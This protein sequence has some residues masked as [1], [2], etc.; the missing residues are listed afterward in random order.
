MNKNSEFGVPF[1][2]KPSW[3]WQGMTLVDDQDKPQATIRR[4]PDL[5]WMENQAP[6]EAPDGRLMV[7]EGSTYPEP[8]FR[9]LR[10]GFFKANGKVES[11]T[12][13]P[14][15]MPDVS[16]SAYDGINCYFIVKEGLLAMNKVGIPLWIYR[17]PNWNSQNSWKVFPSLNGLA[18]YDGVRTVSWFDPK[19][20]NVNANPISLAMG[21]SPMFYA[22]QNR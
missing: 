21:S 12:F 13:L 10:M 22:D 1:D 4:W 7:F 3:R 9:R 16:D 14:A 5:A 6:D 20:M 19:R 18:L 17:P 15:G 2:S 11:Q 8:G